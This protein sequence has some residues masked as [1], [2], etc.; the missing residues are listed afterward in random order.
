MKSE[1]R[2]VQ[3]KTGLVSQFLERWLLLIPSAYQ[4]WIYVHSSSPLQCDQMTC[5]SVLVLH[6]VWVIIRNKVLLS[7]RDAARG[8]GF[9][10]AGLIIYLGVPHNN[11]TFPDR[12]IVEFV[13]SCGFWW[14]QNQ[15][16]LASL[17]PMVATLLIQL[18]MSVQCSW[19]S[20]DHGFMASRAERKFC[21]ICLNIWK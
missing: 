8:S 15:N 12:C 14:N 21:S 1:N 17:H 7:P 19:P 2:Q 4:N 18:M 11:C 10:G 3:L 13:S 20:P 6:G 16:L 9:S 5:V